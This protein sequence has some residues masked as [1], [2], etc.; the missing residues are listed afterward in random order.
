MTDK[1]E[2]SPESTAPAGSLERAIAIAAEAHAGTLDKAYQPYILHPLRVMLA[3]RDATARI[4]AVLHD[5]VEDTAWTLE[6]LRTEGFSEAVLAGVDA[7]TKREGETYRDF[8][9]RAARDPAGRVVKRA[10]ILDNLDLT[11]IATLT[12]RDLERLQ[13]YKAALAYLD[14]LA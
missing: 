1:K 13:D 6:R 5:V 8:V 2:P 10:D 7:V 4:V 11:R 3:Q 14:G 9:A 12:A